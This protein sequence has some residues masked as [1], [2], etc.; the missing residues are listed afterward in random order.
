MQGLTTSISP[1]ISSKI[2]PDISLQ[3]S[4]GIFDGWGLLF[5]DVGVGGAFGDACSRS[6]KRRSALTFQAVD[7]VDCLPIIG[8]R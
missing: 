8:W 2:T 3:I 1:D 7:V 4:P 5:V 6:P